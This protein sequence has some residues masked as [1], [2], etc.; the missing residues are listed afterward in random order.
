MKMN[1][2]Y[3]KAMMAILPLALI[4]C[5]H[6]STETQYK[7]MY[8][9]LFS[10]ANYVEDSKTLNL[11]ENGFLLEGNLANMPN[12]LIVIFE[13]TPENL[14]LI[15]STRTDEQ[16][17]FK[18]Q[19]II[20]DEAICYLQFGDR[21]GFPTALNN[22]SKMQ[23]K[24]RA[25]EQGISYLLEGE[26]IE[27]AKQIKALTEMNSGYLFK[28]NALQMQAMGYDPAV[29]T[30]EGMQ[31][32]QVNM[33]NLQEERNVAIGKQMLEGAPSFA[34]YFALKYLLEVPTY[35]QIKD[36]YDKCN[37]YNTK[38]AYTQILASW[39]AQER[40]TAIGYP[41]P[42]IVM[43]SPQGKVI[44]LSSMKGKVV[45]IDFWASWCR[46]CMGAMPELKAINSKFA[47]QPFAIYGVSLDRDSLSWANTIKTSE[48]NWFHV[49]DLQFW[50]SAA[51]KTYKV[52]SIPATF[53]VDKEGNIA[54]KNLH[55][56]ALEAKIVELLAKPAKAAVVPKK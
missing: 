43:K 15:D 3:I 24:I 51:A 2:F 34:P 30:Q 35:Q 12:N 36:G 17:N 47:D 23:V 25:N 7:K 38:S 27:T 13:Y 39:A 4:S 19:S 1:R 14:T 8:G 21:M 53:L 29:T 11:G 22:Q 50:S 37:K 48:L 52:G 28:L 45:L 46:P 9:S 5:A 26:N 10:S 6:Q 20:A 16:G 54:A 32:A 42:N 55:G 31:Q 33:V 44:P 56:P 18:L 40:G 49:S 41:A